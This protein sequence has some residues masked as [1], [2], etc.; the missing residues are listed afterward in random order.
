MN[1]EHN[2][3]LRN[4]PMPRKGN[5]PISICRRCHRERTFRCCHKRQLPLFSPF[6][7]C[8][9]SPQN[10][11]FIGWDLRSAS[12]RCEMGNAVREIIWKE[13]IHCPFLIMGHG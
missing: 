10:G 7:R 8:R 13:K 2:Y 9:W 3:P 5:T 11:P 4:N 1:V 6:F 12:T